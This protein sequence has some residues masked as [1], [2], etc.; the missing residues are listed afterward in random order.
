[1][2]A[3]PAPKIQQPWRPDEMVISVDPRIEWP[4]LLRGECFW[5]IRNAMES[6]EIFWIVGD[7][8]EMRHKG[9]TRRMNSGK[10]C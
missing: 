6:A 10:Q 5:A 3:P 7:D 1:M 8:P 9:Y 2:K 4:N